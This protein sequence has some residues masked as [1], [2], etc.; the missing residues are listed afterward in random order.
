[1]KKQLTL[2]IRPIT[3]VFASIFF[4]PSTIVLLLQTPEYYQGNTIPAV[5]V[6]FAASM[7]LAVIFN[8][9][10]QTTK[11]RLLKAILIIVAVILSLGAAALIFLLLEVIYR[12]R[13]CDPVHRPPEDTIYDTV[14]TTTIANSTATT[15]HICDPV[16]RPFIETID[17]GKVLGTIKVPE[18]ALQKYRE[19]AEKTLR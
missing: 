3:L 6:V 4:I 2:L 19:L 15:N 13:I 10:Y 11:N 1:M 7:V 8:L 9:F 16:H 5:I 12:P 14:T 17:Y 18:D